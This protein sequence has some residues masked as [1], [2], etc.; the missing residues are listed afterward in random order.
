MDESM[1][2]QEVTAFLRGYSVLAH[3]GQTPERLSELA[4]PVI[5]LFE[6]LATLREIDVG[7]VEMA[8][9]FAAGDDAAS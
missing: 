6:A 2:A 3:L 1:N 4:P 8:V 9:T 7:G 5:A